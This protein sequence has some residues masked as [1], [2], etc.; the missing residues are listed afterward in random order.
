M[1]RQRVSEGTSDK[2]REIEWPTLGLLVGTY[3]A[4][5]AVTWFYHD[6]AW[7]IVLPLGG[8]LVCLHGS[9]QHES[10]PRRHC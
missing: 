9:L 2:N 7:W 4:F 10:V 8:F 6:L 1:N 5:L 3:A